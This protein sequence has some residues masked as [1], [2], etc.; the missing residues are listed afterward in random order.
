MNS[1]ELHIEAT[2]SSGATVIDCQHK[3]YCLMP[4]GLDLY[5]D[6]NYHNDTP[7]P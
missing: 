3:A 2:K 4:H 7:S 1:P 5:V 6:H